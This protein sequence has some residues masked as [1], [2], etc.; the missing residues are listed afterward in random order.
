MGMK[1]I[2]SVQR[3]IRIKMASGGFLAILRKIKS[4]RDRYLLE[5]HD[6]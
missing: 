3:D 5:F 6:V 2:R 1:K 4:Q